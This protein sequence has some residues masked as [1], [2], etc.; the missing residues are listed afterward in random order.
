[1]RRRFLA[2]VC[3]VLLPLVLSADTIDLSVTSGDLHVLGPA[4][5]AFI[6]ASVTQG[7]INGDGLGD[8][9][10]GVPFASPSGRPQAGEVYVVYGDSN[11]APSLDL[12]I[13][14]GLLVIH[15]DL[16]GGQLG[17]PVETGDVNGDGFDDIIAAATKASPP[18]IIKAGRAYIIH[19]GATLADTI[20]LRSTPADV[21][22]T[23]GIDHELGSAIATGDVD[24]DGLDDLVI[25]ASQAPSYGL[26][27]AGRVH[28]IYGPLNTTYDL[29]SYSS[30][31]LVVLGKAANEDLGTDLEVADFDGDGFA[32]VIMAA[33]EADAGLLLRA[34][35][36]YVLKGSP[37]FAHTAFDLAV[38]TPRATV[39]GS[40]AFDQAGYSVAAGDM[41]YDGVPDLAIGASRAAPDPSRAACGI[42]YLLDGD[43]L[44]GTISLADS[45]SVL[46]EIWGSNPGWRLGSSLEI[47]NANGDGMED[48]LIGETSAAVHGPVT[49][50]VYLIAGDQQLPGTIDLSVVGADRTIIGAMGG[51]NTGFDVAGGDINGDGVD[52]LIIAAPSATGTAAASGQVIVIHSPLPNV[53]MSFHDT[54]GF[55]DTSVS[56]PLQVDQTTGLRMVEVDLDVVYDGDIVTFIE[57]DT[58]GALVAGW[59]TLIVTPIPGGA[60]EDPDTIRVHGRTLGASSTTSDSFLD[61]SFDVTTIRAPDSAALGIDYLLFNGGRPEWNDLTAGQLVVVGTDTDLAVTVISTPGDTVRVRAIDRDV[62]L[63]ANAI[64]S[65]VATTTNP[66]T[67]ETETLQLVESSVDDS[68][69]F[70]E[71]FTLGAP[72]AGSDEDGVM[73]VADDDSLLVSVTDTLDAAGAETLRQK[74]HLVI[75]PLGDVDDNDALQAFDASRILAHAVGRLNLSGRDSL[76]ANVDELAPFGSIDSFDAMLV[77]QRALGLIDR[78]PVQADSAANHPQL[79]LGLPAPKILPEVVV[80][81]WEMDGVDLVLKADERQGLLAGDLQIEGLPDVAAVLPAADL[82]DAQ[83]VHHRDEGRLMIALA[84][85]QPAQGPGELLRIGPR[86]GMILPE[87]SQVIL[88]GQF[89]GGLLGLRTQVA[90]LGSTSRPRVLQLHQNHPN[91]FNAETTIRF[92]LP[93]ESPVRLSVY[94]SVGQHIRTLSDE[95]RRAGNHQIVW[96]SRTDDGHTVASGTYVY[97]LESDGQRIARQLLLLK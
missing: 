14:A 10:V 73:H 38:V 89:N 58:T 59:D 31:D 57:H 97:V 69:F 24:G 25:S 74:D 96:D 66:R 43:D 26:T 75:D 32:D 40:A 82:L 51:D 72:A 11:Q 27:Q 65:F 61:L 86:P 64:E 42:V 39:A 17:W 15:G 87:T 84:I 16:D 91:P 46:T 62:N 35:E 50:S 55:Y 13:A 18:G 3:G 71:L 52:D 21:T 53:D 93:Q 90:S 29:D 9:V 36:V 94:N 92:D 28:I 7:D 49:G 70:G 44:T 83:L 63:D 1:M 68:V 12:S 30:A 56:V 34:G 88:E 45:T 67:G 79:Q 41:N 4:A 22:L 47:L 80:L 95:I 78:F 2:M 76:A 54:T 77:I 20:D 81:T 5:N 85:P 8:L 6:G 23:G 37:D 60:P 33:F 19:G 48:L